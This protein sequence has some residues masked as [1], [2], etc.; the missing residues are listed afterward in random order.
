[1]LKTNRQTLFITLLLLISF[2]AKAQLDV[3]S[4]EISY[5]NTQ[6]YYQGKPFT[7]TVY[8]NDEVEIPNK[9]QCSSKT[10]YLSGKLHGEKKEWFVNGKLKY[11]GKYNKGKPIETHL[12]YNKNNE[13]VKK[14]FY[15]KGIQL[16]T[17]TFNNNQLVDK[18]VFKNNEPQYIEH[19]VDGKIVGKSKI[20]DGVSFRTYYYAN[21]N[22][23]KETSHKDG[24]QFGTWKFYDENGSLQKQIKYH[25]GKIIEESKFLNDKK[26][27]KC[28]RFSKNRKIKTIEYYSKGKLVHTETIN[29]SNFV[30]NYSL[31]PD[32]EIISFNDEMSGETLYYVL[33]FNDNQAD[34]F[35]TIKNKIREL[36]LRRANVESDLSMI[37]DKQ[38]SKIFEVSSISINY[39]KKKYER[40]KMVNG[41]QKKYYE[42][43]YEASLSFNIIVFDMDNINLKRYR[44]R[45]SPESKFGNI[46]LN[47]VASNY[48]KTKTTAFNRVLTGISISS[49]L[50]TFFSLSA[51]IKSIESQSKTKIKKVIIN[52]G[53]NSGVYKKM[54]FSVYDADA[55][56]YK[57][58]LKV[59]KTTYSSSICK[60]IEGKGWLKEYLQNNPAPWVKE[61]SN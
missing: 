28:V 26:H 4:D 58:K 48:S 32:D 17:K 43:G 57:A 25:N 60:V 14:M 61:I 15:D 22:V 29:S 36:F 52:K 41:V 31:K 53:S 7:G 54:Y 23:K 3:F 56:R 55:K 40:T 13:I 35:I 59:Y 1:M 24:I 50:A 44:Y 5:Q 16:W 27:G 46:L 19:Y 2:S 6:V 20:I 10:G 21:G 34:N 37:G 49:V 45:F 12:Y 8:S 33:R 47:T 42:I 38:L 9:C 51:T 30:K 39:F 11:S 18:E